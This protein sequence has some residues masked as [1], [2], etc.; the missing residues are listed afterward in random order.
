[1]RLQSC[2]VPSVIA[3]NSAKGR[4]STAVPGDSTAS[5]EV[6]A[7]MAE[8]VLAGPSGSLTADA[9]VSKWAR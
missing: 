6:G 7:L 8:R 1:M 9:V 2:W 3:V 4:R 5:V